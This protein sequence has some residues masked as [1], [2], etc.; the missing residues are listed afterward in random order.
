MFQKGSPKCENI[1][2]ANFKTPFKRMKSTE[3]KGRIL[4]YD[5]SG[6]IHNIL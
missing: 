3:I 4:D 6:T 1:Q 5:S 2:N